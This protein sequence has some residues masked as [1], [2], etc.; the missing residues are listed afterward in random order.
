MEKDVSHAGWSIVPGLLKCQAPEGENEKDGVKVIGPGGK[1][2]PGT[3][4]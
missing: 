4:F 3:G 2:P 1:L